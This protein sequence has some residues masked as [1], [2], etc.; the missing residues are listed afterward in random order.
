MPELRQHVGRVLV[1]DD[2]LV[3]A[4]DFLRE[5]RRTVSIVG[6]LQRRGFRTRPLGDGRDAK[7]ECPFCHGPNFYVMGR[8]DGTQTYMCVA[9][10]LVDDEP[11]CYCRAQ[12]EVI[13]LTMR[14]D[15]IGYHDAVAALAERAEIEVR[16]ERHVPTLPGKEP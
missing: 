13:G 15:N 9:R 6:E 12:G 1:N 8:R 7:A 14:L 3:F 2:G 4:T 11:G 10:S 16:R 5:L